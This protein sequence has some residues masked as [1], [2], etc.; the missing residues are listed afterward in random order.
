MSKLTEG[1]VRVK[2]LAIE[3]SLD[4][5]LLALSRIASDLDA[6][7]IEYDCPFCGHKHIRHYRKRENY[8]ADLAANGVSLSQLER[9]E[10]SGSGAD[11][12]IGRTEEG[13]S[14]ATT[15]RWRQSLLSFPER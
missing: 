12:F 11:A 7:R 14:T 13:P 10:T 4:R 9:A 5:E 8:A 2:C 15:I 3:A 1:P 6:V